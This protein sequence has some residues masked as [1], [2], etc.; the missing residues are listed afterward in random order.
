MPFTTKKKNFKLKTGK[1]LMLL[2]KA[3]IYYFRTHNEI[4][5]APNLFWCAGGRWSWSWV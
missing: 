4:A 2:S 1:V 5:R 3:Q